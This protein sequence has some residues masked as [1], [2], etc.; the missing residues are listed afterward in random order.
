MR[1]LLILFDE[2][3]F[4]QQAAMKPAEEEVFADDF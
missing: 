1:E 3:G 4:L 2:Y